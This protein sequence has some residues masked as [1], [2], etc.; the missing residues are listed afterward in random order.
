MQIRGKARAIKRPYRGFP[1]QS[2]DSSDLCINPRSRSE[3]VSG[4]L[5]LVDG[6]LAGTSEYARRGEKRGTDSD[7]LFNNYIC[8]QIYMRYI[9]ALR[10]HSPRPIRSVPATRRI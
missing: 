5:S 1:L 8:T 10:H 3:E 4:E 9:N 7:E 2:L 6:K